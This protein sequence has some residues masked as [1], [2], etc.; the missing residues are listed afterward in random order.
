MKKIVLI[1]LLIIFLFSACSY[2]EDKKLKI[3]ITNWIGYSPI[4]YAKEKNWLNSLN[5]KILNVASLSENLYLY[6]AGNSDAFVGTQYEYTIAKHKYSSLIPLILFDR[7]NGGDVIMGNQS[8]DKYSQDVS[9]D[10]YLEMDSINSILL[11]DF[12]KKYE[13]NADKIKYINKDQL[14]ISTLKNKEIKNPTLITTYIPYNEQLKK[15]GFIE[16]TSTANNPDLL[17]I[18]AL[19]VTKEKFNRYKEEF[20]KLKTYIDKAIKNLNNNPKEYYL[21]IKK[22]YP[23]ITYEDFIDS[24]EQIVWI[25][26]DLEKQFSDKLIKNSFPLR[27]ILK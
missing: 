7:S 15:N 22:H 14:Y 18:D 20:K 13:L 17:I 16:L 1:H 23:E 11:Q 8:I 2:K 26:K 25:N 3:S 21:T 5:I 12:I 27:D 4:I 19:F 6:S 24:L 10:A 9:I